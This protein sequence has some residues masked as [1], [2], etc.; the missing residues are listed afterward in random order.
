MN[1]ATCQSMGSRLGIS[2]SSE[3]S[4]PQMT[5]STISGLF[6]EKKRGSMG[7]LILGNSRC[8]PKCQADKKRRFTWSYKVGDLAFIKSHT[9][10]SADKNCTSWHLAKYILS[11]LDDPTRTV[12]ASNLTILSGSVATPTLQLFHFR[13]RLNGLKG[14][15]ITPTKL[16]GYCS[17]VIN[18]NINIW[19]H[20]SINANPNFAIIQHFRPQNELFLVGGRRVMRKWKEA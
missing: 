17:F 7:Y 3:S 18:P 8:P 5:R 15:N 9:L 16:F 14:E 10:S 4:R 19:R 13:G 1:S 12:C 2:H 6:W 20:E 11:F